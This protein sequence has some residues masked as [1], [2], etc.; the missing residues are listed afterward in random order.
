[1]NMCKFG[2]FEVFVFGLGCMGMLVF[3]GLIDEGEVIVTI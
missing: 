3:Y 2:L 1:M